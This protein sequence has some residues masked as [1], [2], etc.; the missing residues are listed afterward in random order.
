M[1]GFFMR[2]SSAHEPAL[3]E[4]GA[5]PEAE[6]EIEEAE[7]AWSSSK[8]AGGKEGATSARGSSTAS[9]PG[10]RIRFFRL[11]EPMGTHGA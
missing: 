10:N 2:A 11:G 6:A 9:S 5:L 7:A 1:V 8:A 4:A 3:P